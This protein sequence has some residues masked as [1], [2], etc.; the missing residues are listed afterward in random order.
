MSDLPILN[1]ADEQDPCEYQIVDAPEDRRTL[2]T[3][4]KTALWARPDPAEAD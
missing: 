3:W 2:D 4:L 1:V